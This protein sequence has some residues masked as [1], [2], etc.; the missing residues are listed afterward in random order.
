MIDLYFWPTPNG[1][2]ISIALEEMSVP[3]R[4]VF[5]DLARGDQMRDEFLAISP[6]ARMPAIVDGAPA[7]G[8][9]PVTV[10]E[11][12]AILVYLAEKAGQLLPADARGRTVALQWVMW[13]VGSLGPMLGQ[14]GHFS[15]DAPERLPYAIERYTKEAGRLF[16]VLDR[17]LEARE[18]IADA[19]SIA[20]IACWPW[21]DAIT[22]RGQSWGAYP[23]IARW[24]DR[25][26]TRPAVQR[27][28][29][30]GSDLPNG[31]VLDSPTKARLFGG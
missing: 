19:Y 10:F 21:L 24:L 13:Q 31:G 17:R 2:K 8:G 18:F 9:P 7:D 15:R 1:K 26:G 29:L 11:S 3:Y 20:D 23:Q 30:V 22:K 6:N 16:G 14:M 12:G 28:S 27:G 4:T 5:V 25:V